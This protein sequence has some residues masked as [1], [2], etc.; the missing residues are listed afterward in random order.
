M[1]TDASR[2]EYGTSLVARTRFVARTGLEYLFDYSFGGGEYVA[3]WALDGLTGATVCES[4]F[5]APASRLRRFAS[6]AD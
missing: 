4:V 2:D 6:P 5:D 1:I 3:L